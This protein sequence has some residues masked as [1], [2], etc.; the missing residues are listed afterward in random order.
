MELEASSWDKQQPGLPKEESPGGGPLS[1]GQM[2]R[3]ETLGSPVCHT[4]SLL[5]GVPFRVD[6]GL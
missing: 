4:G 1:L 6:D 5:E 2:R 3:S